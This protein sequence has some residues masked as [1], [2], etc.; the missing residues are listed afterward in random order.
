M[1]A[2]AATHIPVANRDG[3]IL[4]KYSSPLLSIDKT[5]FVSTSAGESWGVNRHTT[6]H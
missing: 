6:T 3:L 4:S 2:D 1:V 5:N